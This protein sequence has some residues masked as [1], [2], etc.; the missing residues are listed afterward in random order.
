MGADKIADSNISDKR[1]HGEIEY[2]KAPTSSSRTPL[3][4]TTST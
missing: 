4:D 2:L 1:H 3:H